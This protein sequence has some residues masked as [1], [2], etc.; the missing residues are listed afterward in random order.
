M[1]KR[2]S[3]RLSRKRNS[4]QSRPGGHRDRGRLRAV[5]QGRGQMAGPPGQAGQDAPPQ[6]PGSYD[7]RREEVGGGRPLCF[8]FTAHC[9][10][11]FPLLLI[12]FMPE[13]EVRVIYAHRAPRT[14]AGPPFPVLK[15]SLTGSEVRRML[16]HDGWMGSSRRNCVRR[17]ALPKSNFL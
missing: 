13:G 17:Q 3:C 15:P 6:P 16:P 9:L 12:S 7:R 8:L 1:R 5:Q 11:P 2:V 14:A 4:Y 10:R